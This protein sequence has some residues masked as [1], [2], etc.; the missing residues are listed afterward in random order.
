MRA[1]ASRSRRSSPSTRISTRMP[2][3]SLRAGAAVADL[4]RWP[5]ALIA[6]AGVF[7]GAWYAAGDVTAPATAWLARAAV[8]LTAVA[9]AADDVADREIDRVAH[10]ERPLPSG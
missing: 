9:N 3:A 2:S 1:S 10:P 5:N 7:T 8:A 4:V 6:A